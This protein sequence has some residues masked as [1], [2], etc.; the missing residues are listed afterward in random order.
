M[1]KAYINPPELAQT[2]PYGFS[3]IVTTGP[4]KQIFLSGQVG[5]FPN[6]EVVGDRDF[7][8]QIWQSFRNLEIAIDKA[9]GSMT[10][11]VSLRLY[12]VA[13]Q[14]EHNSLVS[15][16]LLEFFPADQLPVSTW[17]GVHSLSRP[18]FLFEVEAQAVLE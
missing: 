2:V 18:E 15:E 10:D 17:I 6:E 1:S 3:Q 5:W 7:K 8:A 14:M 13:D 12:I 9:G 16:A 4:G 11:I